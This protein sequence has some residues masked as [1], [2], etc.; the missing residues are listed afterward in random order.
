[1]PPIRRR[2]TGEGS[3]DAGWC[4]PGGLVDVAHHADIVGAAGCIEGD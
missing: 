3:L 4:G 1:M 2:L